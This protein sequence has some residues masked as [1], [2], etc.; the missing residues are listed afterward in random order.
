MIAAI[1]TGVRL[2]FK[3]ASRNPFDLSGVLVWPILYASIAYYLLSP[4]DE[5]SLLLSSSL[6]AAV[7]IMWSLVVISSSGALEQQ[8]WQGTLELVVAAPT[9]LTAVIAPICVAGALVGIY[10]IGATL[11]WSRLVFDVPL[12]ID[13]PVAF[14]LAIPLCAL[15]VGMLGVIMAATFVLYRASFHL[16]IATQGPS[17]LSVGVVRDADRKSIFE[18]SKEIERVAEAI[19]TGKASREELTGSTFT[20]SS[21]GPRLPG[22]R[23]RLP[24][25]VRVRGARPREP[26][27]DVRNTV[28]VI[29]IGGVTSY[30]ALFGWISPWVFI[31]HTLGYPIFEIL[32]FAYLGRF[33]GIESDQFFLIGNAFLAIAV[34]GMFGMGHATAGERRSQ[35]LTTLLAS[36]ANRFAVFLGRAIPRVP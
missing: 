31:P 18:L 34:T 20:I 28:R 13:Q 11:A 35:T 10:A 25:R 1:L 7:M 14:A 19:R 36:P 29:F 21:L 32:F 8:R 33:A 3:Q 6:G 23:R 15:A 17:G 12:H 24:R 2:H 30:R 4:K 27:A 5:P 16:G 26:A 9:P 22:D